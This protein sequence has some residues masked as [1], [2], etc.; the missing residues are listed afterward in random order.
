MFR[1]SL[2]GFGNTPLSEDSGSHPACAV[3]QRAIS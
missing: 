2:I 1:K 3:T